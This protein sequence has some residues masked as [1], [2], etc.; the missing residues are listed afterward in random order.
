MDIPDELS[1]REDRLAA[2]KAAKIEIKRRADECFVAEQAEYEAKQKQR[3]DKATQAG[4][5][6]R[7]RKLK[8]LELGPRKRI[9]SILRMQSHG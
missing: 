5:K 8:P 3:E 7:G 2:I 4:K 1:R 9:K 6:A